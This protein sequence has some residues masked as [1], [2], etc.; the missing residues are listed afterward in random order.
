MIEIHVVDAFTDKPHEGNRAGVVLDADG[1]DTDVMQAAAAFA[2]FSETAFVFQDDN[3]DYDVHVRYFTPTKEVPICGHATIATHFLRAEVLDLPTGRV[4]AKTGAG[5]LP[6][7]IEGEGEDRRIVMTQGKPEFGD[8]LEDAQKQDLIEALGLEI[9][10]VRRDM[11]IQIVSTGHGKVLV[12]IFSAKVLHELKPDMEKLKAIGDALSC[13][14]FFVFSIKSDVDAKVCT[15][16][17]MFAPGIGINEDPVTGNANGP[18]GAYLAQYGVINFDTDF[19]YRGFQG[20]ALGTPG[21]VDVRLKKLE[22]GD[23]QVQVAGQAVHAGS[24]C[25]EDYPSCL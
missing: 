12:P 24:L 2:G 20:Y 11:P 15:Y 18:T 3:P 25:F 6:V 16:G 5:I 14:G 1:L 9:D 4:L 13:P 21:I 8:I 10:Q 23:L 19:N 17:R 22:G 7:D